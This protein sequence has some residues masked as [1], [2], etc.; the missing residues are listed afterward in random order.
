MQPSNT[1]HV[2]E[3]D[4]PAANADTLEFQGVERFLDRCRTIENKELVVMGGIEPPTCGL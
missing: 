2:N 1:P 3:R 4:R